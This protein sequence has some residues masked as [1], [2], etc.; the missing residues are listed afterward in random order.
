MISRA[1]EMVLRLKMM[2]VKLI[3]FCGLLR[4]V[5]IEWSESEYFEFFVM[6]D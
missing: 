1:R 5:E 6:N 3:E 2:G 4:E